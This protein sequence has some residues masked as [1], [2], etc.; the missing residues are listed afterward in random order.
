M[1]AIMKYLAFVFTVLLATSITMAQADPIR[2][3]AKLV[4][5]DGFSLD[6]FGSSVAESGDTVVVGA[7]LAGAPSGGPGAAYVFVKPATGWYGTI[8]ESAKL[9]ASDA[10]D[11]ADFGAAVGIS[12]NTI[13][14]GAYQSNNSEGEAYVFVRSANGWSGQLTENAKLVA[15]DGQL[16]DLLGLSVAI[17]GDVIVA[18][19]PQANVTVQVQGASY[20][21]VKP[22][23]GWTGVLT[24]NAKLTASDAAGGDAMGFSLDGHGVAIRGDTIICG[25][26]HS[27][28]APLPGRA[29]VFVMPSGGWS[30]N[31][32][33]TAE[34]KASDGVAFDHFGNSV[35]LNADTVVIGAL[36]STVGSNASQG[37]AYVFVMPL[38][39][40]SGTLTETAKLAASDGQPYDYFGSSVAI[41]HNQVMVGA[42]GSNALQGAAYRFVKSPGGWKTTSR[43][44]RKFVAFD[45]K[46]G[47]QFGGSV[48]IGSVMISGARFHP[49]PGPGA[50]YVFF[51][52][53]EH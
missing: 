2:Q 46:Q 26:Y 38:G 10:V 14:V 37:A 35:S 12:G 34:L 19:A 5:S 42:I 45:G 41:L 29:Y 28:G 32:T 8:T 16:A 27:T 31:L 22:A 13:V 30:G 40:W 17:S 44:K 49:Y 52:R 4:A 39:G 18:A 47:D 51:A 21:F 25:A 15:S 24:E 33:Q 1:E 53:G 7:S 36:D 6:E 48:A 43:F 20:V 50:A 23:G 3:H 11:Q 9:T